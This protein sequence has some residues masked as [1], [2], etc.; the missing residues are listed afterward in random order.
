M[1]KMAIS[2]YLSIF[3]FSVNALNSLFQRQRTPEWINKQTKI[4]NLSTSFLQV[5]YFSCK[6]THRLK[7]KVWRQ[8]FH[9]NGKEK[10]A[11]ETTHIRQN[12]LYYFIIFFKDFVYLFMR[13][14]QRE[15]ETQAEAETGSS[16]GAG[17]GIQYLGPGIML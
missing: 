16:Q 12:R 11:R 1:N 10:K 15:E 2:T 17:C 8:M 4:Q 13:D 7:L 6:D 14:T 9:S 3:T 5:M